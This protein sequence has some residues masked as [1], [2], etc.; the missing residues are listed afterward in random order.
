[1]LGFKVLEVV[2]IMLIITR[3][4]VLGQ[5]GIVM[6]FHGLTSALVGCFVIG[7]EYL[8][9]LANGF[10]N[11]GEAQILPFEVFSYFCKLVS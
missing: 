1:M 4:L 6:I 8:P 9:S 10:R 5:L 3:L 7:S 11:F 2:L